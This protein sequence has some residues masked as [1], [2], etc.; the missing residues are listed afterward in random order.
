MPRYFFNIEGGLHPAPDEEGILLPSPD[1]ARA[2]AA[3]A[4]GEMLKDL[5]GRFWDDSEWQMH[6][7]DE[8]GVTVCILAIKGS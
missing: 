1:E 7:T 6:V 5:D 3:T 4:A 8:Q 2:Q